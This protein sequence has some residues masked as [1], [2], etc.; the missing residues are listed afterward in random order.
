MR[1]KPCPHCGS[2]FT[3]RSNRQ[4]FCSEPCSFLGRVKRGIIDECWPWTAGTFRNGYGQFIRSNGSHITASRFAWIFAHGEIPDSICVLHKC[5]NPVCCN[6]DHL[7]L[8]TR[9]DNNRD[10]ISKGRWNPPRGESHGR[11]IIN[12]DLVLKIRDDTGS[13]AQLGRKYALDAAHVW[14]IRAQ[15]LW[16]HV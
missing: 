3:P 10:A 7:F 9:G 13:A 11:S 1:T 15:R 2:E 6:P 16:N 4:K 8:G 5:D 14:K 12:E